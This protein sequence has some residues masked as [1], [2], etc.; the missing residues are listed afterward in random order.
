MERRECVSNYSISWQDHFKPYPTI[1]FYKRLT[2]SNH[3]VIVSCSSMNS[4]T[5]L[6]LIILALL[7][8]SSDSFLPR[9]IGTGIGNGIVSQAL[10]SF[11]LPSSISTSSDFR[12]TNW[13]NLR[14]S[15]KSY[16]HIIYRYSG[17]SHRATALDLYKV[18]NDWFPE[19]HKVGNT[20]DQRW[21]FYLLE[22][23]DLPAAVDLATECFF[24]PRLVLNSKGMFY[25]EK[26]VSEAIFSIF[27]IFDTLDYKWN[28]YWG[29]RSRSGSRLAKP[30][31]DV[32]KDSF[33]L[34]ALSSNVSPPSSSS[35]SYTSPPFAGKWLF[36]LVWSVLIPNN[37]S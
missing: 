35:Y 11:T 27:N 34:V 12:N 24:K 7:L 21:T 22:K 1:Y 20:T 17:N 4:A 13:M 3:F 36:D 16:K 15:L 23:R 19:A 18:P 2:Y 29:I 14:L 28:N 10:P 26:L 8:T 6:A 37:L 33:V 9:R 30:S 31:F 25:L 5:V 32:S